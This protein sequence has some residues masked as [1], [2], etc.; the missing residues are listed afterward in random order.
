MSSQ[1][2]LVRQ[3]ISIDNDCII[4]VSHDLESPRKTANGES[5]ETVLRVP[6]SLSNATQITQIYNPIPLPGASPLKHEINDTLV[7]EVVDLDSGKAGDKGS[8]M[9]ADSRDKSSASREQY[10]ETRVAKNGSPMS[11]PKDTMDDISFKC[12]YHSLLKDI[13]EAPAYVERDGENFGHQ[14][15]MSISGGLKNTVPGS[16][17]VQENSSDAVFDALLKTSPRSKWGKKPRPVS[18][19][20]SKLGGGFG[21][22]E[23]LPPS[24]AMSDIE[25]DKIFSVSQGTGSMAINVP[26]TALEASPSLPIRFPQT[27]PWTPQRC[28]S[29]GASLPS[30]DLSGPSSPRSR[31]SSHPHS[32]PHP[33]PER[34][35]SRRQSYFE[36]R[37]SSMT[38][39]SRTRERSETPSPKLRNS[40]K[41]ISLRARRSGIPLFETDDEASAY[42][43]VG[44]DSLTKH[45]NTSKEPSKPQNLNFDASLT[46]ILA[47]PHASRSD[48]TNAISAKARAL[49]LD[50]G[51][52]SS[53]S[54]VSSFL[55]SSD[56]DSASLT[57]PKVSAALTSSFTAVTTP[58]SPH[59]AF[60]PPVG[61]PELRKG[62]ANGKSQ[63]AH[64]LGPLENNIESDEDE[65][66]PPPI[67][68]HRALV[69][70]D[71]VAAAAGAG[72][73]GRGSGRGV[74]AGEG[75]ILGEGEPKQPKRISTLRKMA[76]GKLYA[77]KWKN[78]F[79]LRGKAGR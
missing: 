30:F 78:F 76:S 16:G 29:F 52:L 24:M 41:R 54:S 58:M 13:W 66:Q 75:E 68:R 12:L 36:L 38:L 73:E 7:K 48:L 23:D 37:T 70:N 53:L 31:T 20:L 60:G 2:P 10:Q 27:P 50:S 72:G 11:R 79:G 40:S 26:K 77:K 18:L 67:R 74:D 19:P 1:R 43:V 35:S 14:H 5:F 9:T 21:P 57:S 4:P 8:E 39:P 62:G 63:V 51:S 25:A 47:S 6:S 45:R 56:S 65:A 28:A 61:V 22:R 59:S 44:P 71:S 49:R 3:Q 55:S 33:I 46:S 15:R 64:H 34:T 69:Y 32:S 42:P 17:S